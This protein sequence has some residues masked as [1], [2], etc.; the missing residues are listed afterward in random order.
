MYETKAEDIL[1][2]QNDDKEAMAKIIEENSGLLWS[3]IISS[4]MYRIYKIN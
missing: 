2:A 4:R 3:I 1:K